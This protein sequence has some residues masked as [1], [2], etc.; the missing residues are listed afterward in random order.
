MTNLT[1]E[2]YISPLQKIISAS[3]N[4]MPSNFFSLNDLI[5]L[6]YFS[7]CAFVNFN[8]LEII[9]G[10]CRAPRLDIFKTVL[11]LTSVFRRF[12]YEQKIVRCDRERL[13]FPIERRL[14]SFLN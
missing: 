10:L 12:S 13:F 2:K 11:F 7:K 3:N 14:A 5:N 4:F 9:F 6:K 1:K 8:Y